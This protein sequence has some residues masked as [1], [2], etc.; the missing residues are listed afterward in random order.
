MFFQRVGTHLGSMTAKAS[1]I[2]ACPSNSDSRSSSWSH[3]AD[4]LNFFVLLGAEA[5]I[6]AGPAVTAEGNG[7]DCTEKLGSSTSI[8]GN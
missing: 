7:N 3:T 1:W 2:S 5:P 8:S 6:G 4:I